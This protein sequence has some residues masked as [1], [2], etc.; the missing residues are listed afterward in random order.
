MKPSQPSGLHKIRLKGP[1]QGT[2]KRSLNESIEA[3]TKFRVKAPGDWTQDLGSGFKGEVQLNRNFQKPT[4]LAPD[5]NV[6]VVVEEIIQGME[7][8]LNGE[9]I[10]AVTR[11]DEP[12]AKIIR[13]KIQQH[14]KKHN[15][16]S[17]VFVHDHD[18]FDGG[19]LG[20]VRLEI[21]D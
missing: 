12:T 11:Q 3:G 14:L 19:L 6:W 20:Q 4:N 1:W 5:Q 16:L 9:Q 21:E 15:E 8:W 7:V 18:L 13:E 2:V 17:L 10:T